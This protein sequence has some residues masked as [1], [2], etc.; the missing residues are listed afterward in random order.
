VA[1][2]TGTQADGNQTRK[3]PNAVRL[4]TLTARVSVPLERD[5]PSLQT[6]EVCFA[7]A[8]TLIR[9]FHLLSIRHPPPFAPTAREGLPSLFIAPGPQIRVGLPLSNRPPSLAPSARRRGCV[10]ALPPL[11][12]TPSLAPSARRRGCVLALPPLP[13]TPS[14]APNAGGVPSLCGQPP[15]PK[16]ETAPMP[17]TPSLAPNARLRPDD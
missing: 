12:T 10:L 9:A 15:R 16:R 17:T 3:Q 14:L 4:G 13:T 1:G 2:F 7:Q 11:P 5:N 8:P 6:R